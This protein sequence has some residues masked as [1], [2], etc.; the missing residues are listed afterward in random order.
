MK[1]DKSLIRIIKRDE[2][3]KASRATP[4]RADKKEEAGDSVRN[5]TSTVA[6]WVKEFQH[7]RHAQFS[8]DKRQLLL[9]TSVEE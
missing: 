4:Q 2:R 7:K 8:V 3:E 6:G 9:S 1:S 5:V